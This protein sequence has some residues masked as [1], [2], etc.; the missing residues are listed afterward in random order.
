MRS[1][2][3]LSPQRFREYPLVLFLHILPLAP[4]PVKS[5]STISILYRHRK[6]AGG[7]GSSGACCLER[8]MHS[9]VQTDHVHGRM[10]I[11]AYAGIQEIPGIW[12][13]AYAGMT[14]HLDL[15]GLSKQI[16][17]RS[18]CITR[19][20]DSV[21][22][23]LL[24]P[25]QGSGKHCQV[26]LPGRAGRQTSLESSWRGIDQKQP[27]IH[28]PVATRGDDLAI[29]PFQLPAGCSGTSAGS[30]AGKTIRS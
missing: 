23:F 30:S 3:C 5:L 16:A 9:G 26:M 18:T 4:E 6:C 10:V 2:V 28:R 1:R 29:A 14:F 24:M 13:P 11:P 17:A 7:S 19:S 20:M 15:H 21:R 12:L 27:A 25:G 8:V 22:D